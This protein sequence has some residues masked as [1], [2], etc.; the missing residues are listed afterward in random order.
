[1]QLHSLA[2]PTAIVDAA[3]LWAGRLDT[4]EKLRHYAIRTVVLH[5]KLPKLPGIVGYAL[6]EPPDA[7]A[8]AARPI[9]GLGITRRRV[10]S[11]VIY[12][13]GP[14]PEALHGTD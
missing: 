2:D 4:V 7:A 8:A 12:K 1:M 14:G 9:T 10:G 11:I 6:A 3:D 5:L 13:I